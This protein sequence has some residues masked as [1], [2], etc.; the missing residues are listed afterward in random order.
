M[1]AIVL[2]NALAMISLRDRAVQPGN[3]SVK[4][5]SERR[6][7]L[8]HLLQELAR[9]SPQIRNVD[10]NRIDDTSTRVARLEI[11]VW[12]NDGNSWRHRRTLTRPIPKC[13]AKPLLWIR[14]LAN[15]LLKMGLASG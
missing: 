7:L 5:R 8:D 15:Q 13:S 14:Y 2:G 6:F 12:C 1:T 3:G 10:G 9:G 11:F 4:D